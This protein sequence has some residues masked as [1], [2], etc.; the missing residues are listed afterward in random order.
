MKKSIIV[1][2]V[3]FIFN[4]PGL[5]WCTAENLQHNIKIPPMSRPEKARN[6]LK[7]VSGR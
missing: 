2:R 4:F 6:A 3:R 7:S 5:G 1:H